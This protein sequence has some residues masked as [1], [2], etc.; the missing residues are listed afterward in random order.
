MS[1]ESR[2]FQ[3]LSGRNLEEEYFYQKDRQLVDERR[4]QLD[5]RRTEQQERE[6]RQTHWMHCP[7]CGAEMKEM[8][9]GYVTLEFCSSCSGVFL[10]KG[11]LEMILRMEKKDTFLDHMAHALDRV[12]G[13]GMK[14]QH[15]DDPRGRESGGDS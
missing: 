13:A 2:D 15:G 14:L 8:K 1:D 11:E 7:K 5:R 12:F 6:A 3:T 10:D 4:R 9:R